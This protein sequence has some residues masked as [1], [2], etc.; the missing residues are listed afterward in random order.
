MWPLFK[1]THFCL[2][3]FDLYLL[4]LHLS[5]R[6]SKDD[7]RDGCKHSKGHGDVDESVEAV[8]WN[9][10]LRKG[11][12]VQCH[13]SWVQSHKTGAS[14]QEACLSRT[15][16][17]PSK[18]TR[19]LDLLWYKSLTVCFVRS[20]LIWSTG[21]ITCGLGTWRRDKGTLP[22]LSLTCSTPKCRSELQTPCILPNVTFWYPADKVN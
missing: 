17:F 10:S 18:N 21:W 2:G 7:W 14:S 11:K 16:F 8:L 22:M 19:E 4:P 6:Q 15:L 20:R 1:S 5:D 13:Q 9:S 3:S 12:A